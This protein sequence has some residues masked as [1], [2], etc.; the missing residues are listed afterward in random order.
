M[1]VKGTIAGDTPPSMAKLEWGKARGRE[2]GREGQPMERI[3]SQAKKRAIWLLHAG[4]F[5]HKR[6]SSAQIY[7]NRPE[8]DGIRGIAAEAPRSRDPSNHAGYRVSRPLLPSDFDPR[9]A[10][11]L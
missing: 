4:S 2:A 9:C 11:R 8:S 7:R 1:Y 5:G 3:P 6:V 10:H